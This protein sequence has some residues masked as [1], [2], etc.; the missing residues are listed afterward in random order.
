M[1][2]DFYLECL[3]MQRVLIARPPTFIR[4]LVA[5]LKVTELILLI[6]ANSLNLLEQERAT[7]A[8]S[9]GK[10]VQRANRFI[11]EQI[12]REAEKTDH[13]KTDTM[14]RIFGFNM[15]SIT[16]CFC[17]EET[18]RDSILNVIDLV[19]SKSVMYS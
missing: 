7:D 13:S 9:Y 1:N 2:L 4:H 8:V 5:F 16:R 17:S 6:T 11:L 14:K 15:L 12:S 18:S 3:K 10:L 19:Y